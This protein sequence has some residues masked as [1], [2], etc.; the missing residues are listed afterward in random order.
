[1]T[2]SDSLPPKMTFSGRVLFYKI[3]GFPRGLVVENL[4]ASA[5]DMG[6]IPGLERSHLLRSK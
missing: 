5:G 3:S 2:E 4:P 1:M 6:P